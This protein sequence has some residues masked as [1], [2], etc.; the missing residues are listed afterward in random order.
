MGTIGAVGRF[1]WDVWNFSYFKDFSISLT[2]Y[3][4][5]LDRSFYLYKNRLNMIVF[6]WVTAAFQ[7]W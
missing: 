2:E 4:Y 7:V 6:V 3:T 1:F 5:K